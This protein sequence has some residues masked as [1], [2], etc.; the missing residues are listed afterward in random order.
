MLEMGRGVG[1]LI[2][3]PHPRISHFDFRVGFDHRYFQALNQH[4]PQS[5]TNI[6]LWMPLNSKHGNS[7]IFLGPVVSHSI[8]NIPDGHPSV[9][10]LQRFKPTPQSFYDSAIQRGI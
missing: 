10:P 5:V 3:M 1:W 4:Q 2:E 8:A 6:V 9:G 7:C